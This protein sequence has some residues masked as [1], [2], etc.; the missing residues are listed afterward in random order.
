M[1]T[2]QKIARNP[3]A[4]L[5]HFEATD[6]TVLPG[7]LYEPRRK[8][9]TAAIWLHGNGDASVFYAQRTNPMGAE[10]MRRGLTFFPFNNRGAHFVKKLTRAGAR[11][12]KSLTR[13]AGYERIR[14]SIADV[15]GAVSLLEA[16]GYQR[17]V[18][19]GH[20]SGANKIC[21]YNYYRRR[22]PVSAYVLL[23]GGDDMGLYVEQWGVRR[24]RS[25]LERC[26]RE[27]AAGRKWH[28]APEALTPFPISWMSLYDTINPN[29]DYNIF[30]FLE[31]MRELGLTRKS[32]FREF[33]A[34]AKPALVAYGEHD[35][36]CFGDVEGCM[37]ILK[38]QAKRRRNVTFA[39]VEDSD[40]GFHG[41]EREVAELI[42]DW[43]ESGIL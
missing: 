15:E 34:I 6:G 18:L 22:N 37:S 36:F 43:M 40:H 35:E 26:R 20:S 13:G 41:K 5:V 9:R 1:M 38:Q 10:F 27:L 23:G 17:I 25:V 31:V 30:P 14:E 21:V 33:R 29:G 4:E 39:T 7:L 19:I 3:P 24:F 2:R 8:G 32:L 28:L 16:R 11:R 42:L 12:R